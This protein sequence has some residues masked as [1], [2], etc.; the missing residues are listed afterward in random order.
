[1]SK[2]DT[3]QGNEEERGYVG[4]KKEEAVVFLRNHGYQ[5]MIENGVVMI[6]MAQSGITIKKI[7][8]FLR[9]AG[10]H[11]SYG[12]KYKTNSDKQYEDK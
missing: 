5:A 4:M 8:S 12:V 3:D 10:Y 11:S 7:G 2:S 6:I 9:E 1:M